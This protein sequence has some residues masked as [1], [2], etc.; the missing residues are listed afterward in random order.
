MLGFRQALVNYVCQGASTLCT[1]SGGMWLSHTRPPTLSHPPP[2][3]YL[4]VEDERGGVA[5]A[6]RHVLPHASKLGVP[7]H[8]AVLCRR[9]G[10]WAGRQA[11]W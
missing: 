3:T 9:A 1:I 2:C 6:P 5:A 11:G 4:H 8:H 10:G 7:R